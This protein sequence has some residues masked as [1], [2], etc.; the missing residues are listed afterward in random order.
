[1]QNRRLGLLAV[2]FAVFT[3]TSCSGLD[4]S[5]IPSPTRPAIQVVSVRTS[6]SVNPGGPKNVVAPKNNAGESLVALSAFLT[7]SSASGTSYVFDFGASPSSPLPFGASVSK[8]QVLIGGSYDSN[9]PYPLGIS[10]TTQSG[11]SF[12]QE[13]FV[14]IS[15]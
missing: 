9:T 8:S 13:N 5:V 2:I 1:M 11:R 12:T 3:V 6:G 14:L 4:S 7:I 15:Q 10:G